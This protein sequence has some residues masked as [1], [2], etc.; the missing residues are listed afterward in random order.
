M[1]EQPIENDIEDL[2][3]GLRMGSE[4][5]FHCIYALFS[6]KVYGIAKHFGLRHP[7]AE[8]VVQDVFIKLWNSRDNVDP[9]L[10]VE[11]YI[12][13][14]TR[15]TIIKWLR[16]RNVRQNYLGELLQHPPGLQNTVEETVNFNELNTHLNDAIEKLPPQR[17][18]IF[19]LVKFRGMS[20]QEAASDLC[21]SK[22]TI[23]HH[24]YRAH[25]QIR[26]Q[27]AHLF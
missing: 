17:K 25:Q 20:I 12:V 21:L 27:L 16:A 9:L 1:K 19:E 8:E 26:E 22:R 24:L 18:K 14:I 2:V 11:A 10:S 7:D 23:E 13:K 4:H 3:K 5:S 6:K 15:N